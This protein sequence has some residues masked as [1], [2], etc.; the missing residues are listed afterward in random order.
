MSSKWFPRLVASTLGVGALFCFQLA[1]ALPVLSQ[2]GTQSGELQRSDDLLECEIKAEATTVRVGQKPVI[3]V[4][5]KNG[6]DEVVKLVGSLDASDCRW[7]FPYCYFE[8]EGPEGY[9]P[10]SIG[11]CGNMN[12]LRRQDFVDLA[13]GK[14]FNPFRSVDGYGFFS[15]HQ[16]S[17]QTFTMP[18]EYRITFVYSTKSEDIDEWMGDSPLQEDDVL[19]DLWRT[20]PKLEL[21]SNTLKFM[22]E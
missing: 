17:E 10:P 7:R 2:N 14:T 1:C 22:V 3:D 16:I 4:A 15:A 8:I 6:G 13:P 9:K 12:T 20:V 21:R 19:V 18:G 5:I 11:R